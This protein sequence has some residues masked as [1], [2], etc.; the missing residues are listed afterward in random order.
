MEQFCLA[1]GISHHSFGEGAIVLDLDRDRYWRVGAGAAFVLDW[2]CGGV[3]GAAHPE[4]IV[5]L[6][7]MGLIRRSRDSGEHAGP[8]LPPGRG[9]AIEQ[10]GHPLPVRIADLI[11]VAALLVAARLIVRRGGIRKAVDDV[12]NARARPGRGVMDDLDL[13]ARR[14]HASRTL[15][16]LAAKCLPDT[17]AFQRYAARRGHFPNL[18]FGVVPIPFAAHCWSQS[19]DR[20][21]NDAVGHT[22][23]F[24][25]I[26]IV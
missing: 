3:A 24:A 20:I 6:C 14:F 11:E 16:P 13:L 17:L 23:A 15:V 22:R 5:Q 9:S 2:I 12:R 26:L 18:V 10:P 25:P 8:A 19:G 1:P 21:L 7:E 4:V